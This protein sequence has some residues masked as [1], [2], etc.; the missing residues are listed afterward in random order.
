MSF[1]FQ[2]STFN[3]SAINYH[4]LI[5]LQSCMELT[6]EWVVMSINDMILLE[7]CTCKF[8]STFLDAWLHRDEFMTTTHLLFISNKA[9]Q[10]ISWSS[11]KIS[12]DKW[13]YST[14]LYINPYWH[15]QMTIFW[16]H[17]LVQNCDIPK[18][19]ERWKRKR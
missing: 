15:H 2:L 18:E 10:I 9:N 1:N 17:W 11:L 4:L 8:N 13:F 6:I 14:E 12:W 19:R 3:P 16:F 7:K 5:E